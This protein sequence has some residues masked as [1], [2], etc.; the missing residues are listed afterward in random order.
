[1][2]LGATVQTLWVFEVLGELWAGRACAGTN[3]KELTTCTKKGRQE[4][5]KKKLHR[6]RSEHLFAAGRRPEMFLKFFNFLIFFFGSIGNGP[7]LLEEWVYNTPI[8]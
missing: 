6:L 2:I 1:M 3:E 5:L 8:F 4:E 7:G